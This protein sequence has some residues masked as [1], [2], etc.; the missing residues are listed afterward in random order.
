MAKKFNKETPTNTMKTLWSIRFRVTIREVGSNLFL[1]MF[2]NEEDRLKVQKSC[3]WLFD[4]HV[5]L[6]DKLD[7]ETH[8]VTISLYK[9][10]LWVRVYGVSFLC[11]SEKVG[12]I[13]DETIGDLEEVVV[14]PG[15]KDDNQHLKL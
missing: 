15:K 11:L 14:I 4:K 9:D 7:L 1:F 2:N 6:L 5:L 12:K 13:I 10:F 8:P 3:P